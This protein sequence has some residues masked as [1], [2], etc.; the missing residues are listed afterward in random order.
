M[1]TKHI[2]AISSVLLFL[3]FYLYGAYINSY[4]QGTIN[5]NSYDANVAL[6]NSNKPIAIIYSTLAFIF[7]IWLIVLNKHQRNFYIRVV[8][9][10]II[11]TFIQIL[12]WLDPY[13]KKSVIIGGIT[14]ALIRMFVIMTCISFLKGNSLNSTKKIFLIMLMI[15]IIISSILQIALA[16]GANHY[17]EIIH[18]E[19]ENY[20][21]LM[22]LISILILGFF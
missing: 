21:I 15:L 20:I 9:L 16:Y 3:V 11:Y 1:N 10:V 8:L 2:L 19:L 17:Y 18:P 22:F 13:Q 7:I 5:I 6:A 12:M 14:L 4:R